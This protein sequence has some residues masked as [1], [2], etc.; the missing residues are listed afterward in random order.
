MS[1]TTTFKIQFPREFAQETSKAHFNESK[2]LFQDFD[3]NIGWSLATE[4]SYKPNK[5]RLSRLMT[6]DDHEH[7]RRIVKS[8]LGAT[9]CIKSSC[10]FYLKATRPLTREAAIK[11]S[12]CHHCDTLLSWIKCEVKVEYLFKVKART[13]TMM[14]MINKDC[15]IRHTHVVY[16]SKHLSMTEKLELDKIL[17]KNPTMTPT[18]AVAGRQDIKSI[19]NINPILGN[20]ERAKMELKK[21][22]IRQGLESK[23]NGDF[24]EEFNKIENDFPNLI[25]HAQVMSSEFCIIF[26]S[27]EMTKFKL[28]F[29][30]HPII[31]D[32]TY[33]AVSSG[34]YLVSSVISVEEMKKHVVFFQAVIK[35]QTA[36]QFAFYFKALF[37]KYICNYF[38]KAEQRG[39]QQA[40]EEHFNMDD[41]SSLSLIKGCY[42]HWMQSVQRIIKIQRIVPAAGNAL[43]QIMK[44]AQV[45][46]NELANYY[47][48]GISPVYGSKKRKTQSKRL[49]IT[50]YEA[51]DSRPPDNINAIYGDKSSR[52]IKK[53]SLDSAV[54]ESTNFYEIFGVDKDANSHRI[55]EKNKMED[56][57]T[58]FFSTYD[59]DLPYEL[60]DRQHNGDYEVTSDGD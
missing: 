20:K 39:F 1:E 56:G 60:N 37:K 34:Y 17:E 31:T 43:L 41:K 2:N 6:D 28:P 9:E 48:N 13:C 53:R 42:F 7:D 19:Q 57:I 38:S 26:S 12:K 44:V 5:G 30:K 4:N 14:H 52:N 27:P 59:D 45:Y 8:C 25:N 29:D 47:E 15:R 55:E 10:P 3:L 32:V 33:K 23:S 49:I 18:T 16:N 22:R 24:F 40:C 36:E 50:L 46:G 35:H 21:S 54:E 51:S 11:Q 58:A